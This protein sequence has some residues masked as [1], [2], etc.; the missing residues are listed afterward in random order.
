MIYGF[1]HRSLWGPDAAEFSTAREAYA[2]PVAFDARGSADDIAYSAFSQGTHKCP[3]ERVALVI[4][5]TTLALLVARGVRP[6]KV[7]P[8]CFERAT[9]A[10]RAAP[11][12]AIVGV[13]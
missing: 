12:R 3:G 2:G 8:L 1:P 11:V 13:V 9:L 5:Q 4:V 6:V 7:P 10:Q